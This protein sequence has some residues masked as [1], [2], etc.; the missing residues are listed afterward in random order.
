L[1]P[2]PAVLEFA[3]GSTIGEPA[4]ELSAG[5]GILYATQAQGLY[6]GSI[7]K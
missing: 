5:L 3:P 6:R 4:G 7:L 2:L 1:N